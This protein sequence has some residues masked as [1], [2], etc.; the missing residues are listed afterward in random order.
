MFC[1]DD[2]GTDRLRVEAVLNKPCVH[3]GLIDAKNS[4]LEAGCLSN[5]KSASSDFLLMQTNCLIKGLGD[6]VS[7]GYLR[8]YQ[9][10]L[11]VKNKATQWGQDV[12]V[13][14]K[15]GPFDRNYF[16]HDTDGELAALAAHFEV[17]EDEDEHEEWHETIKAIHSDWWFLPNGQ[18]KGPYETVRTPLLEKVYKPGCLRAPYAVIKEHDVTDASNDGDMVFDELPGVKNF[19]DLAQQFT[20]D[21]SV[22]N[23]HAHTLLDLIRHSFVLGN[24]LMRFYYQSSGKGKP[25]ITLRNIGTK[26]SLK[27]GNLHVRAMCTGTQKIGR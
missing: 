6:E 18:Y 12:V 3:K 2:E 1:D 16:D 8:K 23:K 15:G 9:E 27:G 5:I 7:D 26:S 24:D 22:I 13:T 14:W 21:V 20:G 10:T 25:S 11:R 19:D 17:P 4:W